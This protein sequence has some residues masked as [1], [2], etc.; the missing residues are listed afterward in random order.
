MNRPAARDLL[1]EI[2][3]SLSRYLSLIFIVALGVAFYSGVRASE[4]DMRLSADLFY[5]TYNYMDLRVIGTLGLT[6]DDVAAIAAVPGIRCA[7]GGKSAEAL[8]I[9]EDETLNLRVLS[10][11]E[12]V[13]LPVP[14]SGRMPSWS[15]LRSGL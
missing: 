10:L 7:E 13:S 12:T 15:S 9:S 11:P 6:E 3:K 5:D 4:P 1:R 2:R 14:V 8:S